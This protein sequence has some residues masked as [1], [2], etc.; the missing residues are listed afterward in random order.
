[1]SKTEDDYAE[2]YMYYRYTGMQVY[3]YTG[4]HS[5]SKGQVEKQSVF[6]YS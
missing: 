6:L 5:Y 3:I 1:M 4:I 2:V